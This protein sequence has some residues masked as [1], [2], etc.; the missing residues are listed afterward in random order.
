MQHESVATVNVADISPSIDG[1][2][3]VGYEDEDYFAHRWWPAVSA[4]RFYP[5]RLPQLLTACLHGQTIDEPYEI[6]S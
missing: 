2:L 4:E 1:A 6:W 5:G 3:R